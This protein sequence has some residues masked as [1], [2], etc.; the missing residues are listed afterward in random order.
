[1]LITLQSNS[2]SDASDFVNHFKETVMIEPKSELALVSTSYKF[3]NGITIT[4]GVNDTFSISLGVDNDFTTITVPQG[5]YTTIDNFLGACSTA[6][7]N[8]IRDFPPEEF[9]KTKAFSRGAQVFEKVDATSGR[10]KLTLQY[11]PENWGTELIGVNTDTIIRKQVVATAGVVPTNNR[12]ILRRNTAGNEAYNVDKWASGTAL[13]RA[14]TNVMWATARDNNQAVPHGKLLFKV[15]N[16]DATELVVGLTDGDIPNTAGGWENGSTQLCIAIKQKGD[17]TLSIH[18]RAGVGGVL[19]TVISSVA[20]ADG[21]EVEIHL[22]QMIDSSG[23]TNAKYYVGGSEITTFDPGA[24]RFTLRPGL[25]LVPC[26]SFKTQT[27]SKQIVDG[28]GTFAVPS[29]IDTFTITNPAGAV[30]Y[31]NGEIVEITASSGS[32]T[33]AVATCDVNG[34]ITDLDFQDH[35]GNFAVPGADDSV[36]IVGTFSGATGSNINITAIANSCSAPAN[37]KAYYNLPAGNNWT[38]GANTETFDTNDLGD[39]AQFRRLQGGNPIQWWE[40]TAGGTTGW[41]LYNSKPVAGQTVDNTATINPATGVITFNSGG[42]MVP[43][44]GAIPLLTMAPGN[45]DL[46]KGDGSKIT[47]AVNIATVDGTTGEITDFTFLKF[48]VNNV[49]PTDVLTIQQGGFGHSTIT[50][51]CVDG[52]ENLIYD[53]QYDVVPREV[54]EPLGLHNRATFIPGTGFKATT[55]LP[56]VGPAPATPLVST[57]VDSVK[58]D[59]EDTV[60]LVNIEEFQIKSICKDGGIQKA[61]G[62]VPMGLTEPAFASGDPVKVDGSFYYEPYNMLY[63]RLEN[64]GVENHNQLRVR[65]T[66]A[67]GNPI[68][69]L[70]HPTTITLDLRPRAL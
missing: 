51:N 54:D 22:D 1:M 31:F 53:V 65:I 44:G 29:C 6:L 36:Q 45:A 62:T 41:K 21:N 15:Y 49:D 56:A 59:R 20:V 50:I 39:I 69:Q 58:N 24:T 11:D 30:G 70:K 42:T 52:Q 60:M 13:T 35:G 14:G 2:D 5:E 37:G 12:G 9:W 40:A 43:T 64:A 10:I 67:T 63:H 68:L 8:G 7:Q 57:G 26:G 19:A 66:D 32:K 18:E 46:V 33:T 38:Q 23:T 25:D 17:G 55:K 34:A 16:T 27:I 3:E 61:I 48:L 4:A 47:D 28:G